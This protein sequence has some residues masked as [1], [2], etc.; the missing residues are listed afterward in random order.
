MKLIDVDDLDNKSNPIDAVEALY[1]EIVI[2]IEKINS[3]IGMQ[4]SDIATQKTATMLALRK[5]LLKYP[6]IFAY[7]SESDKNIKINI[8]SPLPERT[9]IIDFE[10]VN[11]C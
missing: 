5:L 4:I 6:T 1:K 2:E 7:F 9:I 3:D 11:K 10:A 8:K